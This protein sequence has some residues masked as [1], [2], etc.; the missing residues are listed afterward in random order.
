MD[1]NPVMQSSTDPMQ[2]IRYSIEKTQGWLKFL[3]ILSIIGGALQALTLVGIIVAWLPIWL[4]IIMNQA[5]S[6]GKDYA[7]RGTLEDL[8]EYND[9]LKNLFTIYGILAI[10]ALIA[11]VL[12]GIVMIILAITGAFVASRYF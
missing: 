9:K 8:V 1:Q 11:A 7:D 2:K 5:G 12:G 10:V 3:G 4:G 6:K